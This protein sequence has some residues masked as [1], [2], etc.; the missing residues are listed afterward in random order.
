MKL[1]FTLRS[2]SH[3]ESID[4]WWRANRQG[5]PSAFSQDF[6]A[7][8]A[9]IQRLPLTRPPYATL[10]RG[11]VRRWLLPRTGHHVY[12]TV[13]DSAGVIRILGVWGGPRGT[14]PPL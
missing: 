7:V 3:A 14:L 6:A 4:A 8:L 5:S 11:V 9:S 12:Y 10:S 13:D 1:A 2:L